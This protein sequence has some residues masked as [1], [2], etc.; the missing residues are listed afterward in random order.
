MENVYI[1]IGIIISLLILKSKNNYKAFI[2]FSIGIFFMRNIAIVH[3]LTTYRLF[4][5]CI[6]VKMLCNYQYFKWRIKRFPLLFLLILLLVNHFIIGFTDTR[7]DNIG[8]IPMF[9]RV[10][11]RYLSTFFVCLTGFVCITT[12][13]EVKTYIQ[14]IYKVGLITMLYMLITFI[15]K[16]D[17]I[18]EILGSASYFSGD[19]LRASSFTG[20]MS[21]GLICAIETVFAFVNPYKLIKE[22]YR[23]GFI[24]LM[25]L[26]VVLSGFRVNLLILA[27]GFAVIIIAKGIKYI[28][29]LIM[30]SVAICCL[31]IFVPFVKNYVDMTVNSLT[32]K[33]EVAGS[34][35]EMRDMQYEAAS[36]YFFKAP[37][38]GNGFSYFAENI[39]GDEN[40]NYNGG[41]MGAEGYYILLMIEEGGIQIFLAS[42]FFLCYILFFLKYR[43]QDEGVIGASIM[44][45]FVVCC[46]GTRPD[47]NWFYC[48][49]II[50]ALTKICLNKRK[51]RIKNETCLSNY[52]A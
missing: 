23:Y 20:F 7:L 4:A 16:F 32:G 5:F 31:Y 17:P 14:F 11:F 35:T 10:A 25:V 51:N 42:L 21:P 8:A 52:S 47:D 36:F 45:M 26:G 38:W 3:P 41:L 19:R 43:K 13:N 50:G 15:L 12:E 30:G 29:P 44:V 39:G 28:K 6:F 49:P 1:A 34:S 22:K 18:N 48:F 9:G 46:I 37:F 33:E 27:G 40:D 2:Y 24:G